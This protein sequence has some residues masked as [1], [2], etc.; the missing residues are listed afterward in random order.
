[1]RLELI[2]FVG[3]EVIMQRR[4]KVIHNTIIAQIHNKCNEFV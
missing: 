3:N 1:M 4:K 2:P